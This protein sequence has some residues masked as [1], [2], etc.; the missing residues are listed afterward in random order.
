MSP[1][2]TI[3]WLFCH[4]IISTSGTD[5]YNAFQTVYSRVDNDQQFGWHNLGDAKTC[6]IFSEICLETKRIICGWNDSADFAQ[7]PVHSIIP[8]PNR[9]FFPE[10]MLNL[11]TCNLIFKNGYKGYSR[12]IDDRRTILIHLQSSNSPIFDSA[13]SHK[14]GSILKNVRTIF[15]PKGCTPI[16]Q[17]RART[18]AVWI[19]SRPA[20]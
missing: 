7:L 15:I 13:T 20:Y 6:L 4:D 1:C 10:E 12:R 8:N 9:M 11:Y 2:K 3:E 18:H 17:P 19:K 16:L 5:V 14:Q